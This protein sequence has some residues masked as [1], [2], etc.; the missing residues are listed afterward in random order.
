MTVTR[1]RPLRLSILICTFGEDHWRKLAVE[2][3]LPSAQGQ[4]AVE[5]R[6]WHSPNASLCETRNYAADAAVGDALCFLD[7]D[8]ELAPGYAAAM[9]QAAA[10]RPE[11]AVYY[12]A[13]SYVY[14]G[15]PAEP[16]RLLAQHRPLVEL[17]RAVIGSVIR[18]DLFLKLGGFRELPAL[19][20]WDLWLRASI[21]GAIVPVPEAV[22]RVHVSPRSRNRDQRLYRQLRAEH[23]ARLVGC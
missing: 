20:D 1:L 4:A 7:A 21:H 14:P 18:R 11:A 16:P 6:Q 19:E 23:E 22:Y 15:R 10:E 8:D 12:P 2:R 13:V 5:V 9:A 17:N 3:A